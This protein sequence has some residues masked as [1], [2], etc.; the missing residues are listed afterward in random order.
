MKI[1]AWS[2]LAL[3]VPTALAIVQEEPASDLAGWTAEFTVEPGELVSTGRNPFFVLEPGYE[4]EYVGGGDRLVIRVLDAVRIVD[5]VETRIVEERETERGEIVEISRNYFA[6][7]T[8][9]GAVFYFGEEVDTYEG[10]VA[11]GHEGAWLAGEDGNRYGLAMP[12]LPLIG[13]RYYQ[14]IAPGVAMDR[15]E[16]V[17]TSDTLTTPMKRFDHVLTVAE[18]TPLEP[19]VREYKY[20]AAGAGLLRDESMRLVSAGPRADTAAVPPTGND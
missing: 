3:A 20:Y 16:I 8:R 15:A 18:T 12:A 7:S 19:G 17:S 1:L 6:I 11:T 4:L 5:G 13:A 10:G 14:E 9:T 2:A